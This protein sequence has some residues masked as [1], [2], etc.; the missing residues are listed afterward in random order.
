MDPV[1]IGEK[2]NKIAEYWN[3]RHLDSKYGLNQIEKALKFVKNK[4]T[5]LDI[6]CGSGGRI[7]KLLNAHA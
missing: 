1:A 2:Y 4:N 3:E 6:G 5:A 7:V